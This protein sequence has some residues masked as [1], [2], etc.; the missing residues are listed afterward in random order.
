SVSFVKCDPLH[1]GQVKPSGMK[2]SAS[3]AYQASAVSVSKIEATWSMSFAS[4]ML[5][6][7]S[8]QLKAG[9]GTP[10]TLCRDTHQS[11]R[12]ANMLRIRSRPQA[13]IQF[14]DSISMSAAFLKP[15]PS[16]ALSIEINH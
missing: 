7:Q 6:P 12:P 8:L 16:E 1:F 3:R 5:P 2:Y 10:H 11:G 13:G 4:A 14:T 9:I 15:S